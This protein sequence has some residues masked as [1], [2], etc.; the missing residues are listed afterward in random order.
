M[1]LSLAA[2]ETNAEKLLEANNQRHIIADIRRKQTKF[3]GHVL[4]KGTLEYTVTTGK[5]LDNET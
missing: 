4:K 3:I 2:R 1:G 5:L